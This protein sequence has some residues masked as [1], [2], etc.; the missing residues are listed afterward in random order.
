MVLV[1]S[2]RCSCGSKFV[3]RDASLADAK[4][5]VREWRRSH[6]CSND[7]SAE[8]AGSTTGLFTERDTIGFQRSNF[9]EEE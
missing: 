7:D 9:P 6:E 2:E 4:K 8:F 5:L 1:V 3:I